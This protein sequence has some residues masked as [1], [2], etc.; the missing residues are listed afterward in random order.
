MN[1]SV[2]DDV[3]AV[4]ATRRPFNESVFFVYQ[5]TQG[6]WTY[7]KTIDEPRVEYDIQCHANVAASRTEV[8][9]AGRREDPPGSD[10]TGRVY[11]HRLPDRDCNSNEVPDACELRDGLLEDCNGDEVADVCDELLF[12]DSDFSGRV[13]LRDFA[14]L[15]RCFSGSAGGLGRCCRLLDAA[16]ADGGINVID[17]AAFVQAMNGPD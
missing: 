5:K 15:Q 4:S 9:V 16:P 2:D 11:I 13:D 3:L 12:A 7:I 14:A 10:R 1:L 17:L 8:L 6:K